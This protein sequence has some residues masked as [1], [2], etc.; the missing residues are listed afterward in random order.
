MEDSNKQKPHVLNSFSIKLEYIDSKNEDADLI[1][2]SDDSKNDKSIDRFEN[3]VQNYVTVLQIIWD[4]AHEIGSVAERTSFSNLSLIPSL[5][6]EISERHR[7]ARKDEQPLANIIFS[8][9]KDD[10]EDKD[11][12]FHIYEFDHIKKLQD[13]LTKHD[14]ALRLLNETVLQQIVNAWEKVLGE[15]VSWKLKADPDIIPK[16]KKVDCAQLLKFDSLEEMKRFFIEEEVTEFLKSK[17]TPEQINYFKNTFSADL[18]SIFP[19]IKELYE[20]ILCRHTIVHNG[21][22]ASAEY[23]RRVKNLNGT[24]IKEGERLKV[25]TS[26]IVKAWTIIY[27]AGVILTHLVAKTHA[28]QIKS[29]EEEMEADSLLI[30]SS[31]NN[32]KNNQYQAAIIILEY[33]TNIHLADSTSSLMALVNLAQAYKWNKEESKCLDVLKKHSWDSCSAN[34]RICVAALKDD[35]TDFAHQLKIVAHEKSIE[36][37]ELFEWPVFKLIKENEEFNNWI[38]NA[39]GENTILPKT[40][41]QPKLLDFQHNT[42]IS[43]FMEEILS[44]MNDSEKEELN[45]AIEL[46]DKLSEP[47]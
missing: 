15:L 44:S 28:R 33:A 30:N 10:D 37:A 40:S 18:A 23:C 47:S 43:N 25:D 11:I 20:I 32:L 13:C 41:S 35:C 29:K 26:Y 16:D 6:K 34:F 45:K 5:L 19:R 21:G 1:E 31:Y 8:F 38:I 42:T 27:S 7:Q 14:K 2:T 3:I 9:K 22:I 4:Y 39:Y 36:V 46:S 17:S 12:S 24:K